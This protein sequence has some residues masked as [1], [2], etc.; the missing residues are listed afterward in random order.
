MEYADK[1]KLQERVKAGTEANALLAERFGDQWFDGFQKNILARLL[2]AKA[3][4]LPMIQAHYAAAVNFR[5]EL[6]SV[7]RKGDQ[8]AQQLRTDQR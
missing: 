8:A 1:M 4:E 7:K 2:F 3:E 5:E 6:I